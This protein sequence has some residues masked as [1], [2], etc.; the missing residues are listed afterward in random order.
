MN[1]ENE[2]I[3]LCRC[4]EVSESEIQEIIDSGI[5]DIAAIRRITR[6]GMGLCQGQTCARLLAQ[7]LS[8]LTGRSPGDLPPA[9][10]RPPLRPVAM[11]S[12][13]D[14]QRRSGWK[15]VSDDE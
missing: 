1:A 14:D 15:E 10:A 2:D 3:L 7:K 8:A 9:L 4:E 12:L 13:A 11:L 5:I 6:A